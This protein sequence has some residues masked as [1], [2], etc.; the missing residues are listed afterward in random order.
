MV[1]VRTAAARTRPANC[2]V[3]NNPRRI[4]SRVIRIGRGASDTSGS[5]SVKRRWTE[6]IIA[7]KTATGFSDL[8]AT[9]GVMPAERIA[10]NR[11]TLIRTISPVVAPKIRR[12]RATTERIFTRGS[13]RW[14]GVSN[15]RYWPRG[16][17]MPP[18]A[19]NLR[20]RRLAENP[21]FQK[22]L[23]ARRSAQSGPGPSPQP[24]PPPRCPAG[25]G[26]YG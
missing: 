15:G 2:H 19:G 23:P 22:P 1:R 17:M 6:K 18:L 26:R 14:R 8:K 25:H 12:L 4:P 21:F 11:K 10:A 9:A 7:M 5:P 20:V 3:T 16:I 24:G 13:R